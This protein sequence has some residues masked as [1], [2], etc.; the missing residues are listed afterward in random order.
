MAK[1]AI[2]VGSITVERVVEDAA[3]A[4]V[5]NLYYSATYQYREGD[6]VNPTPRQ[7]LQVCVDNLVGH[8]TRTTQEYHRRELRAANEAAERTEIGR[9]NL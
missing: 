1:I 5:L 8:I 7:R 2:T 9:I 6:P 4:N 3:A